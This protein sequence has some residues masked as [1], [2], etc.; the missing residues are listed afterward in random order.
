MAKG[1]EVERLV[2]QWVV[3][4]QDKLGEI[5]PKKPTE[6]ELRLAT[7]P[8]FDSFC[9]GLGSKYESRA[10]YALATGRADATFNHFVIEYKRPGYLKKFSD[11]AT[12]SAIGQLRGYISG[13]AEKEKSKTQRLAGVVFDGRHIIFV[14]YVNGRWREERVD[15][16]NR[17]T[18]E[19]LLI[20][21]SGTAPGIAL[22]NPEEV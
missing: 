1:P 19:R 3:K 6:E 14:R 13:L 7:Y 10:E 15:E 22:G 11:K 18:L 21:L 4:I 20:Q 16:V 17:H 9:A 8:L 5:L 12:Y 2:A